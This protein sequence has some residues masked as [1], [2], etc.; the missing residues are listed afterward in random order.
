MI[1]RSMLILG[2][3][4]MLILLHTCPILLLVQYLSRVG[5]RMGERSVGGKWGLGQFKGQKVNSQMAIHI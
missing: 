3:I 4:I 2:N 1:D 5:D